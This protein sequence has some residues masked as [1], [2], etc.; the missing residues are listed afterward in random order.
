MKAVIYVRANRREEAEKQLNVI[1]HYAVENNISVAEIFRDFENSF[2][3]NEK[4]RWQG[5]FKKYCL[6]HKNETDIVLMSDISSLGKDKWEKIRFAMFFHDNSVNVYFIRQNFTLFRDEG[7][8][9]DII[10]L[11]VRTDSDNMKRLR[12]GY[13]SYMKRGGR[14]GRKKMT[15]KEVAEKY[16]NV[17]RLLEKGLSG[18]QT[19]QRSGVSRSTVI[20]IRKMLQEQ[21]D[22]VNEEE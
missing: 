12:S 7:T 5:L 2:I 13:E 14:T 8:E 16:P 20:M 22:T 1:R 9:A 6:E 15:A 11:I 4:R 17:I 19:A 21:H 10:S 18:A 3:T